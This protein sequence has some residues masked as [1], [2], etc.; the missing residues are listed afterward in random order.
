MGLG[1]AIS[2]TFSSI[3][4]PL[5]IRLVRHCHDAVVRR[6]SQSVSQLDETRR[7]EGLEVA[8]NGPHERR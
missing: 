7:D 2:L 8:S 3:V 6:I 1:Y 4:N 5:R